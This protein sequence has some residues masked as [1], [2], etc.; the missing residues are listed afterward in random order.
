MLRFVVLSVVGCSL[1][2]F[3]EGE[4]PSMK[5][6]IDF[7]YAFSTP[8]RITVARPD[9]GDKTLLDLEP[10][11]LRMAWSYESLATYPFGAFVTP[12]ANW[13][14]KITPRIDGHA[15][16][17]STWTRAEGF[18]PVLSNVYEDANGTMALEVVGGASAAIVRVTMHNTGTAKQGSA[19]CANRSV[20][21][22]ATTRRTWMPTPRGTIFWRLGRPGR[23]RH[24]CRIWRG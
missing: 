18:L 15:F 8:H 24:H 7:S 19:L 2:A 5:S 12:P 9:S 4:Q 11:V 10:G 22:L 16:A 17:K 21:S 3:A 1:L 14:V 23:P 20:D 6:K 13:T